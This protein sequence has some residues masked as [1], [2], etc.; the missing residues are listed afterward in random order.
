MWI[1][2]RDGG[3]RRRDELY[4]IAIDEMLFG[5]VDRLRS[6]AGDDPHDRARLACRVVIAR[7]DDVQRDASL[8]RAHVFGSWI[9]FATRSKP[10]AI[11]SPI[12]TARNPIA[13]IWPAFSPAL[14]AFASTRIA[15][16]TDGKDAK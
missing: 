5:F 15:G 1:D 13:P 16:A 3:E 14:R 7:L 8:A 9:A 4:E 2:L 11:F 12:R 10:S 6:V